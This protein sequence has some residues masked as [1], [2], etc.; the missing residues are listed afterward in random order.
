MSPWLRRTLQAR[1]EEWRRFE[2]SPGRE[3]ARALARMGRP[4]LEP[5]LEA[6]A[7]RSPQARAHAA[8][9]VGEMEPRNGRK[10]ALARLMIALKDDDAQVREECARALGKI[11]DPEAVPA[12]LAALRDQAA[13]VRTATAWALGEMKAEE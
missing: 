7:A 8:L 13:A 3:A 4:A 12:L 2:T 1:P 10:E 9:G 11:E 5:L 6:L